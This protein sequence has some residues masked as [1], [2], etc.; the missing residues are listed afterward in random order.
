VPPAVV[1]EK[2]MAPRDRVNSFLRGCAGLIVGAQPNTSRA[3]YRRSIAE[4]VTAVVTTGAYAIVLTPFVF[5]NFLSDAWAHCYSSDLET[6]FAGRTDVCVINAWNL[7]AVYPRRKMLLHDG[8][9]LSRLAHEVLAESLRARLV[10][11][12]QARASVRSAREASGRT[13]GGV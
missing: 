11:W 7:L 2:P 3:D 6:D 9:H 8:L 4:V 13:I 10:G 5:D 12:I 1:S